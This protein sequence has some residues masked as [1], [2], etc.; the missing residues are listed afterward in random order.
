LLFLCNRQ[1]EL[2]EGDAAKGIGQMVKSIK[3]V[4]ESKP[5]VKKSKPPERILNEIKED[6]INY[7]KKLGIACGCD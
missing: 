4:L 1:Q 2:P 6:W 3:Q 7:R 5:E